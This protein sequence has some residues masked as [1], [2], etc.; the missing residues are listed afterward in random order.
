MKSIFKSGDIKSSL[1]LK[2]NKIG[3]TLLINK[4]RPEEANLESLHLTDQEKEE[5]MK[6]VVNWW[7]EESYNE[8]EER[9]LSKFNYHHVWNSKEDVMKEQP[10][11]NS[12]FS[13]ND[14]Y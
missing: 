1:S 6:E 4:V 3:D 11:K 14:I 9:L 2:V 12:S 10:V 13:V 7:R 5:V 8:M